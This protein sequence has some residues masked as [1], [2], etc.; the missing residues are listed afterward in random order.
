MYGHFMSTRMEQKKEK[1]R[2]AIIDAAEEIIAEKGPHTM[3]MDEIARKA[4][5]A[6]G[7]IYLYFK[8]K[9]SLCAA[10]NAGLNKEVNA[11]IKKSMALYKTGSDKV[12]AAG[13]GLIQFVFKNPQ[14]WKAGTELYQIKFDDPED[15]NVQELMKEDNIGIQMMADAY[16]QAIEEGT[17]RETVDP[18]PTAIFIKMAFL[19][20]L[21]PTSEQKMQLEFNNITFNHYLGVARDLIIRST[22]KTR[23]EDNS[24]EI[25]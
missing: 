16:Q 2:K 10:V 17:I 23:P 6:T 12:R 22:H 5:V 20:A 9:T 18:I 19:N 13:T 15:P 7:T 24:V 3:N 4:D 11:E 21:T 14:M 1:K 8:N 25:R